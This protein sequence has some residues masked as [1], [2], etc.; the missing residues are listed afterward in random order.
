MG[1]VGGPEVPGITAPLQ[2]PQRFD[3]LALLDRLPSPQPWPGSDHQPTHELFELVAV[4]G[5]L[6]GLSLIVR[7]TG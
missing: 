7:P 6:A 2:A 4:R 3:E 5:I 1:N